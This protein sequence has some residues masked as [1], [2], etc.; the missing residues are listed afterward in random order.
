MSCSGDF[1]VTLGTCW[2][3]SVLSCLMFLGV[4]EYREQLELSVVG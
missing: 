1:I 3:H 4:G 2:V